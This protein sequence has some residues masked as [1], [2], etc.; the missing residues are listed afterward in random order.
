M[1]LDGVPGRQ[2]LA[3]APQ[4]PVL[5]GGP[6]AIPC[7]PRDADVVPVAVL[8]AQGQLCHL[9]TGPPTPC[10]KCQKAQDWSCVWGGEPCI[11]GIFAPRAGPSLPSYQCHLIFPRL[12]SPR[13]PS[14]PNQ[15]TSFRSALGLATFGYQYL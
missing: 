12:P 5:V 2:V 3:R 15:V 1:G 4:L 9:D 14:Q 11:F 8:Q 7:G 6:Q 10:Q 13:L